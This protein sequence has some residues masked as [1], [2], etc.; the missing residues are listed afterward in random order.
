MD[1]IKTVLED[2]NENSAE[3]VKKQTDFYTSCLCM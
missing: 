1:V 2:A 3:S